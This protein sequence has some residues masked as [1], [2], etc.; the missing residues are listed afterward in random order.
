MFAYF[1]ILSLLTAFLIFTTWKNKEYKKSYILYFIFVFIIFY[2]PSI[3]FLLGGETYHYFSD[4]T[5][6]HYMLYSSII[7]FFNIVALYIKKTKLVP[8]LNEKLIKNI[9]TKNTNKYHI[10]YFGIIVSV[11]FTYIALYFY[12][13]PLVSYLFFGNLLERPDVT[14]N[15]PHF[16]TFSTFMGTIVPSFYFYYFDKIKKNYIH[17]L[18]VIIIIILMTIGGHKGIVAF[19][20]IFYWIVIYKGKINYKLP[21]IILLLIVI[22][23]VTKGVNKLNIETF[24]YLLDSPTRRFFVTQGTCFIYRIH[25]MDVN[26]IFDATIPIK[27][28]LCDIMNDGKGFGC[29]AP[30]FFIGDLIIKYGYIIATIIYTFSLYIII[31]LIKNIDYF[32][33]NNYFLLWSLFSIFY[34]MGMAEISIY[35]FLRILSIL[36]NVIIVYI[37]ANKLNTIKITKWKH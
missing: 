16:Y 31:V 18:S 29:S 21:L 30:T 33:K 3:Y 24:Q 9:F 17:I 25:A 22:Y 11:V 13:F 8:L 36:I 14:G 6:Q 28:Q 4:K 37:I 1:S 5:L 19:F 2:T 20:A 26:Y 32:L 27:N 23:A 10:I 7:I 35:S 12:R 34:L 15:I